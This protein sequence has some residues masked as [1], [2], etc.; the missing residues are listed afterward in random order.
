MAVLAVDEIIGNPYVIPY[1]AN[2]VEQ[3][4]MPN[5]AVEEHWD[6]LL[7]GTLTNASYSTA[8]SK[9]VESLENLIYAV[10][11]N[12]SAAVPGG[13]NEQFKNVD[14]A[15]LRFISNIYEQQDVTRTDIGTANQAYNFLTTPRL[16][17]GDP[18]AIDAKTGKKCGARYWLDARLLSASGLKLN[19]GFRD[20]T[21]MVYG[22]VAGT[23]TLSNTTVQVK[24]RH[25]F[26]IPNQTAK[27][28]T[29]ARQYLREVQQQYPVVATGIDQQF[30]NLRT[31][32]VLHRLTIKGLVSPGTTGVNFADPSD[33]VLGS[34][35]TRAEGPHVKLQ[36]NNNALTPLDSVYAQLQNADV[37]LFKLAN[38][39]RSGY[40]VYEPST[41]HAIQAMLN[42]RAAVNMTLWGDTEV[43]ANVQNNVQLTYVERVRPQ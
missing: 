4:I 38:T 31:G 41:S 32:A 43:T 5:T 20:Q 34:N 15:Y 35:F 3:S 14:A 11:V 24:S 40:L 21:A 39:W 6:I 42:L 23:S 12:A 27:G 22:G 2:Q 37:K 1:T 16:Y 17:F 28:Q 26:G 7:Q 10:M 19:V 36:V 30:Y 25:Y 9:Y 29:I 33:A 8:P 18:L 13:V